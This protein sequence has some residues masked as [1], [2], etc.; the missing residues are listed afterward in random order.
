VT[1]AGN[2]KEVRLS[3]VG[4]G[5][6]LPTWRNEY[7]RLRPTY[8][9][10]AGEVAFAV[11]AVTRQRDIKT[12][13]VSS[14]VKTAESLTHKARQKEINDPL[15]EIDDIVGIR[16]VV[17]F[18]SDLPSLDL[19][20]RETFNVHEYDDKVTSGDPAS[21][22][23]MSV[24]YVATLST[25]HSGPR[26]DPIK[27]IR[28][29]IQTRTVVMD[30]WAN[31]SHYL[32]Y[33]GESSV[34]EELKKDFFA[35]SGLFY[36]ADQ[37]FETFAD[38]A[39]KSSEQATQ[40]LDSVP[41]DDLEINLDTLA[42]YLGRRYAERDSSDRSSI[43]EMVEELNANGYL[44]IGSIATQLD[45]TESAFEEYERAYPPGGN[46]D[47]F[48]ELGVV[49]ISLAL[50]DKDYAEWRYPDDTEILEFALWA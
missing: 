45:K 49:R 6:Q 21:F 27:G 44:T 28:F 50:I 30:A 14:R 8:E 20:I 9:E 4:N 43:S 34:P 12:H 32:D 10:L 42:A 35:L 23:Y 22:G 13:S 26:Y 3:N 31:V 18:L 38:R 2:L 16:V 29:E 5:E 40:R 11:E 48:A 39:R 25:G 7:T 17:L 47:Q 33:K 37:H 36:V 41:A 1:C 15:S 24:H 46:G 19:L